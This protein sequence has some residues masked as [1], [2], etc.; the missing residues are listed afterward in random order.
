NQKLP[1]GFQKAEFLLEHGMV[2]VIA[3]RK[4]LKETIYRILEK[5]V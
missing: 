5:L 3:E 4:D 1:K 2:D